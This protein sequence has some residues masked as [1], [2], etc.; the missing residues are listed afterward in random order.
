MVTRKWLLLNLH[1]LGFKTDLETLLCRVE[2][3]GRIIANADNDTM[4]H[5][6]GLLKCFYIIV[7]P[8]TCADKLKRSLNNITLHLLNFLKI[9]RYRSK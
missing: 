5:G 1:A 8:I 4:H 6:G 7:P 3:M 2:S 9:C